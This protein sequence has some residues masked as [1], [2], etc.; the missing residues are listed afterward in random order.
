MYVQIICIY[1]VYAHTDTHNTQAHTTKTHK[2]LTHKHTHTY[3]Y[4]HIRTLYTLKHTPTF[5][6]I[7]IFIFVWLHTGLQT[8]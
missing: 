2:T 1:Y 8:I 3:T 7:K 5:K 4:T 6:Q